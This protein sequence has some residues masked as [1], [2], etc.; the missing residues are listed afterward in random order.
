MSIH[1]IAPRL[2]SV[3]QFGAAV[4]IG[5]TLAYELVNSGE[6]ETVRIRGRILVPVEAVDAY[7]CRL[8][9]QAA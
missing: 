7:V 5:K 1:E 3:R 8:R 6:V 2:I 9:E 4:G